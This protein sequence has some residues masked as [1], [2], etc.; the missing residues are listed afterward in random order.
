MLK[1]ANLVDVLSAAG[2]PCPSPPADEELPPA[3]VSV[4]PYIGSTVG[5]AAP[6]SSSGTARRGYNSG[7]TSREV[8]GASKD[9]LSA[10]TSDKPISRGEGSAYSACVITRRLRVLR[11]N[12][13]PDRPNE[14]DD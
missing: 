5:S 12:K 2:V 14:P 10:A 7:G 1:H 3:V 8:Y 9:W 13:A 6:S 11:L 4:A